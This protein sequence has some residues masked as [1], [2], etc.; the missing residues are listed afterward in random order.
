MSVTVVSLYTA[1]SIGCCVPPFGFSLIL[2]NTWLEPASWP[3]DR[4]GQWLELLS[5]AE[6]FLVLIGS[7]PDNLKNGYISGAFHCP[8]RDVSFFL[9]NIS[10]CGNRNNFV[11]PP[12]TVRYSTSLLHH[13]HYHRSC[14]IP[15]RQFLFPLI[16]Y[17]SPHVP[18]SILVV[19]VHWQAFLKRNSQQISDMYYCTG[20]SSAVHQ[21]FTR[22]RF[23]S[24]YFGFEHVGC[25][26]QLFGHTLKDGHWYN[27]GIRNT[28]KFTR[29]S[30]DAVSNSVIR[31]KSVYFEDV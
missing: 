14:R 2:G 20:V 4:R 7:F 11:I 28:N 6:L 31:L 23:S 18:G 21:L 3:V 16:L 22:R 17:P 12:L 13:R 1:T 9:I 30:T 27:T 5:L 19:S 25:W 10:A 29:R 8:S 26:Q 24:F 15:F